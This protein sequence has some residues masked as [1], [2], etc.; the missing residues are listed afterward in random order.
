MR[1]SQTG[2]GNL[3]QILHATGRCPSAFAVSFSANCVACSL[4]NQGP[5]S[6]RLSQPRALGW[7]V[8][9]GLMSGNDQES[10]PN[11]SRKFA[12]NFAR[13]RPLPQCIRRVFSANSVACILRIQGP[14][15]IRHS[16]PRALGWEFLSGLMSGNDHESFPNWSRTF[17]S[18]FARNGPLPQCIRLVIFS[19]FCCMHFE[20]SGTHKYKA[21]TA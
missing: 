19:K 4:R 5:M 14:M 16:Q 20:K 2:R 9:S 15:S 21:F 18:N 12:S 8:L 10:F 11:W 3:P 13:N 7:E 17:A 1:V 6:T